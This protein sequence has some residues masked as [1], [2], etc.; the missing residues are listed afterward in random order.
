MGDRNAE[1]TTVPELERRLEDARAADRDLSERGRTS[2]IPLSKYLA[3]AEE[4]LEAERALASARGEQ[5]AVPF[6]LG[7][8]PQSAVPEP[9]L[10]QNET[11]T[12]LMFG[13]V[14]INPDGSVGDPGTALVRF[15]LCDATL[16]GYPNDEALSGH[17][18]FGRGLSFYG[19]FEVRNSE[20]TRR[21]GDQNRVSFP[22]WTRPPER[23][24]VFCFH[25]STFE[26]LCRGIQSASISSEPYEDVY[27]TLTAS[28][29]HR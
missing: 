17:P 25:D 27:R 8:L 24:L 19:V 18:L 5:H 15:G 22:N 26:C 12:A 9:L 4:V 1:P 10:L 3:A 20:W 21:V 29:L 7:F 14:R 13:A 11:S 16:F 2:S 6:D 23:H 28:F